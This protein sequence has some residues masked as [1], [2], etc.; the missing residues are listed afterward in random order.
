MH[1]C[2]L[3]INNGQSFVCLDVFQAEF[4]QVYEL[5]NN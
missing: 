1:T 5:T 3:T 4:I 2:Y